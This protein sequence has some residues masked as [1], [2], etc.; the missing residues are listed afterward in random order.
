[1]QTEK[2]LSEIDRLKNKERKL[3]TCP[4][5]DKLKKK[6]ISI[7]FY[8]DQIAKRSPAMRPW[9]PDAKTCV[10]SM[11]D[12]DFYSSEKSHIMPKV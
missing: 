10:A 12:G 9:K 8:A 2:N 5:V 3:L 1:M 11:A 4:F 6:F 7:F